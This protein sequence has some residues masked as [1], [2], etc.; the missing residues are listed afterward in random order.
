MKLKTVYFFA[1][2]YMHL[3]LWTQQFEFFEYFYGIVL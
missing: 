1:N 2:G 3:F